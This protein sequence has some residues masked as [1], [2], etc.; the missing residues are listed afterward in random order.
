VLSLKK[1]KAMKPEIKVIP[2]AKI[3]GICKFTKDTS[4]ELPA[5]KP[6]MAG[7]NINPNPKEAP[8]IPIFLNLFSGV[9]TS[10]AAAKATDKLP[11]KNPDKA[12][13]TNRSIYVVA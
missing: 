11:D 2:N 4:L 8:S 5:K 10:E 7:P 13:K 6:P 3:N 12:L 1:N 9:D